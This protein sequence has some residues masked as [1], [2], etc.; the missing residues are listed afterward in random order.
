MFLIRTSFAVHWSSSTKWHV[1]HPLERASIPTD[2]V[3]AKRSSHR[4]SLGNSDPPP[5]LDRSMENT[6]LLTLP[7][8]GRTSLSLGDRTGLPLRYPD[9]I[10]ITLCVDLFFECL[11][12]RSLSLPSWRFS[13]LRYLSSTSWGISKTTSASSTS[14]SSTESVCARQAAL[15]PGPAATSPRSKLP[16]RTRAC[17]SGRGVARPPLAAAARLVHS[18]R[19]LVCSPK[20]PSGALLSMMR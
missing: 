18:S 8:M 4:H 13:S 14:T 12:C 6:A 15:G 19:I 17:T 11:R 2:P 3:P 1:P 10:F 16:G 20:A 7:I 5:I 9:D